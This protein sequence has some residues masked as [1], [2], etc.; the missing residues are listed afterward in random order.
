MVDT[1]AFCDLMEEKSSVSTAAKWIA[2][3]LAEAA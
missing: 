3:T 2:V 1:V